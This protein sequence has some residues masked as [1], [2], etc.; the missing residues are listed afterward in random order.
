MDIYTSYDRFYSKED[1][2]Y[3][4][5]AG[6]F[7]TELTLSTCGVRVTS[8]KP[9]T[10][11][12]IKAPITVWGDFTAILH[13]NIGGHE[14]APGII[15]RGVGTC[16][17]YNLIA[18]VTDAIQAEYSCRIQENEISHMSA[19]GVR[20]CGNG[21]EILANRFH[22]PLKLATSRSAHNDFIQGYAG[23][24]SSPWRSEDRYEGTEFLEN[25]QVVGN[26]LLAG[27]HESMQ[28]YT[29]FDGKMRSS[30]IAHNVIQVKTDHAITICGGHKVYVVGNEIREG[31]VNLLPTR[32]GE[33]YQPTGKEL[34]LVSKELEG[35]KAVKGLN[36]S[37]IQLV[38]TFRAAPNFL[39]N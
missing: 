37:Q 16:I 24:L 23:R 25:I 9:E 1:N 39:V 19:D 5:P 4:L 2:T 17:A 12:H 8:E 15:S 34:Y 18:G 20:F 26:T 11:A 22:S 10:P 3:Y 28:G 14:A 7:T 13:L 35:M 31:L 32:L 36:P 30:L 6:L 29:F 33:G 21:T 38:D 27:E